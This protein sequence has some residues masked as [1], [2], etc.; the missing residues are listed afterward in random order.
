[1]LHAPRC[2]MNTERWPL[3]M[4]CRSIFGVACAVWYGVHGSAHIK[5]I[6]NTEINQRCTYSDGSLTPAQ[7]IEK[8]D[9]V[10]NIPFISIQQLHMTSLGRCRTVPAAFCSFNKS[11]QTTIEPSRATTAQHHHHL[12]AFLPLEPGWLL[13]CR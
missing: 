5:L 11:R 6:P 12:S 8:M 4:G 2:I 7:S 13:L 1:M 10:H 9:E 3:R